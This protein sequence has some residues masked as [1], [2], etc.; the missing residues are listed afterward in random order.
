MVTLCLAPYEFKKGVK[1]WMR[2]FAW[3]EIYSRKP[4]QSSPIKIVCIVDLN[5]PSTSSMQEM[6][7]LLE[8]V[9][10]L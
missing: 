8:Q 4:Q 3:N 1:L 5:Y 6:R 10:A 7:F 2:V 9:S